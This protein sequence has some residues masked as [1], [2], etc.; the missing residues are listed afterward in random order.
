MKAVKQKTYVDHAS[1]VQRKWH[2]VDV[3]DRVLGDV[4]PEIARF[5]MG[6]HKQTYTP[7]ID[8]G[9]FVVVINM[10]KIVVTGRKAQNKKYVRHSGIPGGYHA[11]TFEKLIVR[12]PSKVLEHAVHGMLPKNKMLDARLSRLKV[13]ATESYKKYEDKFKKA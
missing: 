12:D 7:N 2:L 8:N 13:F 9:D 4:A 5:L 10:S 1:S 3:A 6:K 11:E